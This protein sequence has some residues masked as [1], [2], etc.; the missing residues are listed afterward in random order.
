MASHRTS[1]ISHRL[2]VPHCDHHCQLGLALDPLGTVVRKLG[3]HR[4]SKLSAG[5]MKPHPGGGAGN[6]QFRCDLIVAE[7]VNVPQHDYR[8]QGEGEGAQGPDQP[9]PLD[10]GRCHGIGVRIGR[11][12]ATSRI[13]VDRH[14]TD[15][16]STTVHGRCAVGSDAVKPGGK[17]SL[18]PELVDRAERPKIGLLDNVPGVVF[19]PG[20]SEGQG[21]DIVRRDPDQL[22]E[23]GMV[24]APG[25]VD[26][27]EMGE[28]G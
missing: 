25:E 8:A 9:V 11:Q 12:L 22:F 1:V 28:T 23:G 27:V 18:A 6:T 17:G 14:Q 20:Q 21:I 15:T 7:T 2:H 3:K 26:Q 4:R 24:T 13:S 16:P 19:I 10:S 5:P